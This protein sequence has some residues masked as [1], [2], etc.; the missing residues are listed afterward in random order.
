MEMW[1][2]DFILAL[3]GSRPTSYQMMFGA[4]L[5]GCRVEHTTY[6]ITKA[7]PIQPNGRSSPIGRSLCGQS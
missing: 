2:S 6:Q 7:A 4:S 5:P 1:W 3:F